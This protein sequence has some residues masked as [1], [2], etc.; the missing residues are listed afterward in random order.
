LPG[1]RNLAVGSG[2]R[3]KTEKDPDRYVKAMKARM[4]VAQNAINWAS[5]LTSAKKFF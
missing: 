2:Q 5:I 4:G 1:G 3:L